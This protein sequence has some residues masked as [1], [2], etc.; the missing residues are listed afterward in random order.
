M[1]QAQFG[2]TSRLTGCAAGIFGSI[3]SERPATLHCDRPRLMQVEQ[4]DYGQAS[5]AILIGEAVTCRTIAL[6]SQ[7]LWSRY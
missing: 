5:E 3:R 1:K 6:H 4:R 2:D 7:F